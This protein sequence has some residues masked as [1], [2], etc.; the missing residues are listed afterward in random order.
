AIFLNILSMGRR[1]LRAVGVVFCLLQTFHIKLWNSS[2]IF[3]TY[4]KHNAAK[5]T[6]IKAYQ[7]P[8]GMRTIPATKTTN[9]P[10][11]AKE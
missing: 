6:A 8:Q 4:V 10:S 7:I 5:N 1:R 11:T 2:T 3:F 9:V